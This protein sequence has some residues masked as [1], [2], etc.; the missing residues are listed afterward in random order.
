MTRQPQTSNTEQM[1]CSIICWGAYS[2]KDEEWVSAIREIQRY[3]H[4]MQQERLANTTACPAEC[5]WRW[6]QTHGWQFSVDDIDEYHIP[7][8]YYGRRTSFSLGIHQKSLSDSIRCPQL[9]FKWLEGWGGG[10]AMEVLSTS[11]EQ[12]D[13]SSSKTLRL[14]H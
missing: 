14:P 3:C 1:N 11:L 2:T 7:D 6:M 5:Q 10:N 8:L 13:L 4:T 12:R 9:I